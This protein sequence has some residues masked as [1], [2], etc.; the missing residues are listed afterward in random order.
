MTA[1]FR[2]RDA[3][4]SDVVTVRSDAVIRELRALFARYDVDVVPVV[5][6]DEDGRMRRLAGVVTRADLLQFLLSA[7]TV[8]ALERRQR[9]CVAAIARTVEPL[10]PEAPLESAARRLIA[11]RSHALP[12]SDPA[13][14]IVGMLSLTNILARAQSASLSARSP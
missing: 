10:A 1:G 6:R 11:E 9:G 7:K 3:M 12:V 13:G 4:T 5:A 2:V 8:R 14:R